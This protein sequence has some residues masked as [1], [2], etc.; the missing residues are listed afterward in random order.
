[1]IPS[2]NVKSHKRIGHRLDHDCEAARTVDA[3]NEMELFLQF[4][5]IAFP[6]ANYFIQTWFMIGREF[7]LKI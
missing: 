4:G 7:R 6:S 3:A 5:Y 2:Y 1:M